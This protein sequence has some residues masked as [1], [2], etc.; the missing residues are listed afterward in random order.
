[1]ARKRIACVQA[2]SKTASSCP[3]MV[4]C[5]L[6]QTMDSWCNLAVEMAGQYLIDQCI[7]RAPLI[8]EAWKSN[9]NTMILCCSV[10]ENEISMF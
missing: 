2:L 6:A 7:E 9:H 3:A 5:P 10:I 8:S 4:I 1:M